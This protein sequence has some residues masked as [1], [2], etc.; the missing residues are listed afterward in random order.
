MKKTDIAMIVLIAGVSVLIAFF[1][2]NQIPLLKLDTT[3]VKVPKTELIESEV[4]TP[5]PE[6]FSAE[7]INPT[8]QTVIG[9]GS[10][11]SN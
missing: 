6:V 2:A 10:G 1:V 5:S 9:G 7:N 8:V 11:S 3:G 4:T